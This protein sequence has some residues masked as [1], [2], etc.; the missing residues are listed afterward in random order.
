MVLGLDE[1]SYLNIDYRRN[2]A[3]SSEGTIASTSFVNRGEVMTNFLPAS[4]QHDL[5]EPP[6]PGI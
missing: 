5:I 2:V 1:C 4:P 6:R 3:L